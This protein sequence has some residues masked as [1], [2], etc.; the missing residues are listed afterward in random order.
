[1]KIGKKFISALY[2]HYAL[3]FSKILLPPF[4]H[5]CK[6]IQGEIFGNG[7]FGDAAYCTHSVERAGQPRSI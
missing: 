4:I 5:R 7:N 3:C 6:D 2:K 1:M